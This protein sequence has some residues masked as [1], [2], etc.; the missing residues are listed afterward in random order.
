M[1]FS[2]MRIAV[3]ASNRNDYV[4]RLVL[5]EAVTGVLM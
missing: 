4:A 2:L 5:R 1:A 3:Q